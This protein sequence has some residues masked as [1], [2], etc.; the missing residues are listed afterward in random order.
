MACAGGVFAQTMKEWDDV[1]V[2]NLN[3]TTAHDLS[4]PFA[5]EADAQTLDMEK[6]PY[7]QSL[8]GVWK[9]HWSADPSK[10]VAGF[11]ASSYDVSGWDDIDVPA[12]WQVYGVRNNKTWDKPLYVNT[13]YP[14]TYD[15][16]YSVMA[17]RPSD[18]TYNSS[19]MNP[20]GQYRRNFTVPADWNGRDVF[21]RFNGAGHGYYVWVNGK[22]AGYA[23]D[24]YLPSEFN[25]TDLLQSGENSVSVQV[26]RFTS[27]SFLE[28][29]DYWRLTGITRDVYLW[30][31]PKQRISDF[32]F[33]TTTLS[34]NNTSARASLKVDIE[35][36]NTSGMTVEAVV[37]DGGVQVVSASKTMTTASSTLTFDASGIEA[38][39]AENPKLYDLT[40]KL[41][42]GDET[43]DIR[44]CKVGFR[45]V[46]VRADGALCI[47]GNRVVFHGVDR[48]DHSEIG[49][50][51]VTREEMEQDIVSMKQLNV[52]AVRTSHYPNNP[53][54]Y[55]LCDKYGIYVLAEA[56][57]EC[58]GNTGLSSVE[59]F[60]QPMVERSQRQV[61][62]LRNHV[63]IFGWSGGNESGGGDNFSSVMSAIKALDS[64]RLTHYEGN[65]QWSDV[66]STMYASYSYIKNIGE[67][68]LRGYQSGTNQRPHIQCENTHSMGNAMGNQKDMFQLYEKY[69]ALTGEFVWDWKDQGLK[70]PVPNKPGE[71]YWAYGGDFGDNPNDGNF[72]C[73]GVVLADG[74]FTAKTYNMKAVYQPLDIVMKDSLGAVFTMKSKLAHVNLDYVDVEYTILEDGV[75]VKHGMVDELNLRPGEETEW[76]LPLDG[77][78]KNNESEYYVRFS[79][80]QK[81]A[82]AW[83]EAGYEVASAGCRLRE[84]LQR[85]VYEPKPSPAM[86]VESTAS[87]VTVTGADFTALFSLGYLSKYTYKEKTLIKVGPRLNLFRTPTDNDKAQ[88]SSWMNLGIRK[89]SMTRTDWIV[90]EAEDHSWVDVENVC[91]YKAADPLSFAVTQKYRVYADGTIVVATNTKPTNT[92]QILPKMGFRLEM[93]AEYDNMTWLGMGPM[94]NYRDRR[95]CALEGIYH[96]TADDQWTNFVKPQECGNKE[97]VSWL[98]MA[99]ADGEGLLFIAPDKMA[100]TVGRWKADDLYTNRD[101]RAMHPYQ[102]K[103]ATNTIVCLDAY[104]RALGN[105]SCGPDVLSKYERYS[106][107]TPF[108]YIII[109][110]TENMS[111]EA[112]TAKA[113]LRSPIS[114]KTEDEDLVEVDKSL[115]SIYSFDSEQGGAEL[116]A[117]AIDGDEE[118]IWHT[119][120]SPS[121]PVCPHELVVDMGRTYRVTSFIYKGRNDGSNGRIIDYDIYFSNDPSVW[122]TPAA[123]GSWAD[124]PGRQSVVINGVEARYFKLVARSVVDGRDYASA[125]ELY[126]KA[127][128][129]LDDQTEPLTPIVE[130]HEYRIK[131]VQSGLYLHYKPDTGSNHEGDYQLGKFVEGDDTYKFT[132]AKAKGYT[133]HYKVKSSNKYMSKGTDGWRIVGASSSVNPNAYIQVELLDDG[134]AYL[135]CGWQAK[136]YVNFDSHNVGSFIYSDKASGAKFVIEDLTTGISTVLTDASTESSWYDIQGRRQPSAQKGVNIVKQEGK[137]ATKVIKK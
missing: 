61:R 86:T 13:R 44:S 88:E 119:Q 26:Y 78:M 130:G 136:K 117:N 67:E 40:L 134:S 89:P 93:P 48:H 16:K 64:S 83:A 126:V 14:F 56:D 118:T 53:Y 52:N 103:W 43:V 47:N 71:Y 9:F 106:D 23:E 129:I 4:I 116:A 63:C 125:A 97:D 122:K 108:D 30:S 5:N 77:V 70:M 55:E 100:T 92:G 114:V 28:C 65:S 79:A 60:R 80:R 24:S 38:W 104:N 8:N 76:T 20:V 3:R 50:R 127:S 66:T 10:A 12:C 42:N 22:F 91:T 85:D 95:D 1:K 94:D 124:T 123:T 96:S 132:F 25:V 33:R 113:R 102:V 73:N 7:W 36:E 75:E 11:E 135:R 37:S 133:S 69:P 19:M 74:S 112:I 62:T 68:R 128:A 101:T 29:Q 131:D 45:T 98:R 39:S 54:F 90:T 111:D 15:S 34:S 137:K 107:S 99:N 121:T 21:L 41:K 120:Y 51:T 84:P 110:I 27:G 82:T 32:F 72:C 35:G 58:H 109:P 2:T 46:S 115:W 17:A 49:G 105:A 6:S 59:L 18:Y 57:V 31:A 87:S 81:A